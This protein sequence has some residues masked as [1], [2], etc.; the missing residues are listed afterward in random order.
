MK[1]IYRYDVPIDDA[2]H[3]IPSGQIVLFDRSAR[4]PATRSGVRGGLAATVDVWVELND[5]AR[6]AA[7][8][9]EYSRAVQIVGTGQPVPDDWAWVTS[10][11][12]G[13]LVWHLY[14]L[15]AATR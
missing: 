3:A 12:D 11:V 6:A 13:G 9:G 14:D 7:E 10:F 4:H 15:G 1:T 8:R 2:P 5:L